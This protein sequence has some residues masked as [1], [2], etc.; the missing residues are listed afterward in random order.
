[1]LLAHKWLYYPL[2][3]CHTSIILGRSTSGG[4]KL[5]C[6][7]IAISG[8]VLFCASNFVRSHSCYRR[9]SV[10]PSVCLSN[11]CIVPK[12]KHLAKKSLI[13]T[14]LGSRLRAFQWAEDEQR[15]LPNTQFGY[16]GNSVSPD[17]AT[18]RTCG[19]THTTITCLT[20]HLLSDCL[21]H[22]RSTPKQLNI[23]MPFAC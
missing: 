14:I 15:T 3:Y 10:C 20:L 18:L 12:L 2:S 9:L 7:A 5:Q 23:E 13:M 6:S 16:C 21:S 11:A 22:S 17:G 1:M 8:I 4:L 19:R